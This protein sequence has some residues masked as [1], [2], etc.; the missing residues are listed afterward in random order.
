MPKDQG[1][2]FRQNGD[3][4]EFLRKIGKVATLPSRER[5]RFALVPLRFG[6]LDAAHRVVAHRVDLAELIK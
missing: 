1:S 2:S 3:K 5:R 4:R 6:A